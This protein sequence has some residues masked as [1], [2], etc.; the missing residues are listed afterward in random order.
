MYKETE[1]LRDLSLSHEREGGA[2]LLE[3]RRLRL[4]P[5]SAAAPLCGHSWQVCHTVIRATLPTPRRPP[6]QIR[7]P[8]HCLTSNNRHVRSRQ[9][10]GCDLYTDDS[11]VVAVLMHCGYWSLFCELGGGG[12][13]GSGRGSEGD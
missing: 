1:P 8:A 13:A 3:V 4:M 5:C 2:E 10:W 11:D 6:P 12:P 9:L 7:V